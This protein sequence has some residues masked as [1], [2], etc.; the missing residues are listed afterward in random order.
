MNIS[1]PEW[2]PQISLRKSFLIKLALTT[3]GLV[4]LSIYA[5]D[6]YLT[7]LV[8]TEKYPFLYRPIRELTQLAEGKYY[9]MAVLLILT[10]GFVTR[11]P[12]WIQWGNFALISLL[13]SG[14]L[15]QTL[16]HVFGRQRPHASEELSAHVFHFFTTNWHYHS[17]PSGHAQTVF[18]F[19]TILSMTYPKYFKWFFLL[20]T[21]LAATRV[22]LEEHF[23]SDVLMGAF[24]G[25][26]GVLFVARKKKMV[27]W[28]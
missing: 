26:L 11:R 9:F 18:S 23:L 21:L 8:S 5:I 16:K 13:V 4:V 24:I 28:I 27:S 15:L 7:S 14:I 10:L 19:A 22:P 2:P 3:L 12:F 1:K 17:F 6:P 20:A 25:A